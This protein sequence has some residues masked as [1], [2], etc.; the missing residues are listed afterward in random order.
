MDPPDKIV[1]RAG[2][3]EPATPHDDAPSRQSSGVIRISPQELA[4]ATVPGAVRTTA[5]QPG[6]TTPGNLMPW[7]VW[8][9]LSCVPFLNAF[10]WWRHAPQQADSRVIH[11]GVAV[12]LG[13]LSVMVLI[14][15]AVFLMWPRRTWLEQAALR[16]DRSVV[17]IENQQSLGAGFVIAS[18][19]VQKL[20]LT[21]RHVVGN[22]GQCR[23]LLRSGRDVAGVFAGAPHDA[24]VDLALVLVETPEL[25]PLGAVGSFQRVQA[26][27]EVVAIGHPLGL[28][29][30]LTTGIISAKRGGMEL[31]S[32]APISPGNSGGPLI[33]KR[34]Y[35]VGVNTRTIAPAS[36]TSLGF[37]TRADY[38]FETVKWH[39]TRDIRHLLA[40][41]AR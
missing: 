32:S 12:L 37:A 8:A 23:I 20:I 34:G 11:R 36:G 33:S 4:A 31:Q 39:Y 9:V 10:I 15:A 13:Y 28:D 14:S 18:S 19:G 38:V 17:R 25:T 29:Y 30:T 2:D 7:Y 22:T 26:G 3:I 40:R 1:I 27:E 35:I 41:V 24:G 5:P 16:A 21:N 6:S